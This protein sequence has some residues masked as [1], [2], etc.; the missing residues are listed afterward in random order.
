M[1]A[2]SISYIELVREIAEKGSIPIKWSEIG[3]ISQTPPWP[4]LRTA[5]GAGR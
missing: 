3:F 4:G 2:R 1:Y 5:P